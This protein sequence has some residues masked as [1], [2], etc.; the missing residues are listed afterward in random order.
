ML[1]TRQY[2]PS[3]KQSHTHTYALLHLPGLIRITSFSKIN[4]SR[5][6]IMKNNCSISCSRGGLFKSGIGLNWNWPADSFQ[7]SPWQLQAD[8][9]TEARVVERLSMHKKSAFILCCLRFC[10]GSAG[11]IK[12]RSSPKLLWDAQEY[13]C[14]DKVEEKN[15]FPSYI[16]KFSGKQPQWRKYS[17]LPVWQR[18]T[19]A[20]QMQLDLMCSQW[21]KNT[22]KKPQQYLNS[23]GSA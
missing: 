22:I 1:L 5:P 23:W 2:P 14:K 21:E 18:M 7:P 11:T 17:S 15:Q 10:L 12:Q 8:T 9:V 4:L 20:R 6:S 13:L 16:F 19:T 3:L